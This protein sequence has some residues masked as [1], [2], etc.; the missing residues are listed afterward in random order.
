[1]L[2]TYIADKQPDLFLDLAYHI[3][4]TDQNDLVPV[5]V[6]LL[7]LLGSE[8]ALTLLQVGREKIGSPFIRTYCTLGLLRLTKEECYRAPIHEYIKQQD[9]NELLRLR[10][11]VPW[12]VNVQAAPHTLTLEERSLL[13]IESLEALARTQDRDA[14]KQL[15]RVIQLGNPQN[16]ALLAALL[17]FCSR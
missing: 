7:E 11:P 4:D 8:E 6:S 3:F 1:M 14:I 12:D 2:L 9:I 10:P 13:F 17:S 15:L 5:V 16:R